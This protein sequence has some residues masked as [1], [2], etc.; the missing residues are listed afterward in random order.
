MLFV[1]S[2]ALHF[3]PS[4]LSLPIKPVKPI[5]C[6]SPLLTMESTLWARQQFAQWATLRKAAKLAISSSFTICFDL[7]LKAVGCLLLLTFGICF[8]C[9]FLYND[10]E[11]FWQFCWYCSFEWY[12]KFTDFYTPYVCALQCFSFS[13]LFK[14]QSVVDFVKKAFYRWWW[15]VI[16]NKTLT[17]HCTCIWPVLSVNECIC[18][19]KTNIARLTL[20]GC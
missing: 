8:Y 19:I 18:Q 7:Q 10:V 2:I 15:H 3:M 17:L 16:W 4:C 13:N 6:L 14:C 20:S 1:S 5:M 12:T 11:H 9:L